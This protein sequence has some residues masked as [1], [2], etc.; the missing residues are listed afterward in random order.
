MQ[1]LLDPP[2]PEVIKAVAKCRRAGIRVVMVTG[3]HAATAAA[4]ASKL[5]LADAAPGAPHGHP[6][7]RTGAQLEGLSDD[8]LDETIRNVSV[9]ARVSPRQ[10]LRLVQRFRH[11]GEIV[12]VTGDGVNDAPALKAA[13]IGTAMGQAGTEVSKEASDMILTDDNFASIYAA[14]E[15]GRTVFHNIRMATFF[16]LSSAASELLAIIVSLLGRFP[17]PLLPAQILWVNV[18][19]DGIQDVALAFEK[20][21]ESLYE[22]PPRSPKEGV[23][24]SILY[25]RMAIIGVLFAAGTL[26][27]F[28]WYWDS[29]DEGMYA[30]TAA[31]TML[32]LFQVFHVFN[33]RSEHQSVFAK[34]LFSNKILFW[35]TLASLAIHIAALYIPVMQTLLKVKPL[36]LST[37][38]LIVTIGLSAFAANE[39]HKRFRG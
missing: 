6:E 31:L 33:C 38:L 14:V 34:S 9:Y 11:N 17:L 30:R 1:G 22:C 8:Q 4:I 28:W 29:A 7:A 18:V 25:E 10:K 20:G 23:L 15:E 24:N 5:N 36:S 16:L 2:R 19:T 13:H 12:A 39:L 37:W 35:G 21:D 27:M 3:D 32:V 26:G